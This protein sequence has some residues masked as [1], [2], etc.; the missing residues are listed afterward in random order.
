MADN[1]F[2][3]LTEQ[4]VVIEEKKL[5]QPR[6]KQYVPLRTISVDDNPKWKKNTI[7]YLTNDEAQPYVSAGILL[8]LA[9]AIRQGVYTSQRETVVHMIKKAVV[10]VAETETKSEAANAVKKDGEATGGKK[11]I[12]NKL[13]EAVQ[14]KKAEVAKETEEDKPK[15]SAEKL[16]AI[17]AGGN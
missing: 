7:V 3:S 5:I 12:E 1:N 13:R 2:N 9:V 15:I 6:L 17:Q 11:L 10:G 14:A 8:P 4:H 16:A